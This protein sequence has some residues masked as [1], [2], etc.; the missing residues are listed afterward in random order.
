MLGD[1]GKKS[2]ALLEGLAVCGLVQGM[3]LYLWP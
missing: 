1:N 2:K 3:L